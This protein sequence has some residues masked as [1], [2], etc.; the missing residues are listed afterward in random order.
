M[1]HRNR[2]RA[3]L[4][5]LTC[6][7]AQNKL[8]RMQF[9]WGGGGRRRWWLPLLAGRMAFAW[10]D[11]PR[12]SRYLSMG[13]ASDCLSAAAGRP[14]HGRSGAAA[15]VA[16]CVAAARHTVYTPKPSRPRHHVPMLS[17][18]SA[19]RSHTPPQRAL[20]I[21]R[22]NQR[23]CCCGRGGGRSLLHH[24]PQYSLVQPGGCIVEIGCAGRKQ[25][26]TIIARV[27]MLCSCS[28]T[29]CG[30][31]RRQAAARRQQG[32]VLIKRPQGGD[33]SRLL[34]HRLRKR[35]QRLWHVDA[36]R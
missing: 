15:A 11:G 17:L 19:L 31:M 6:M 13:T 2:L 35:R 29:P 33:R 27:C 34:V 28:C 3:L 8:W 23:Y 24:R 12:A 7:R 32:R 18:P 4:E 21:S 16:E 22:L 1:C 36:L 5:H 20:S 30:A 10:P 25:L 26:A 14:P 9:A